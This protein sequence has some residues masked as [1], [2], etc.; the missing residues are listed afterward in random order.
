MGEH[1][2]D[3]IV[4]PT[5]GPACMSDLIIGDRWL[6]GSTSPAAVA[7][8]PSIT[9]PAVGDLVLWPGMERANSA[10]DRLRLRAGDKAPQAAAV[11]GDGGTGGVIAKCVWHA[12]KGRG[13][14]CKTH[15]T[16]PFQGVPP[17]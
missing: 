17:G 5:I 3:A 4:A 6:G 9:V 13:M 16:T 2:L 15:A 14:V 8:Y 11:P 1:K 7:G 12:L 10:Q